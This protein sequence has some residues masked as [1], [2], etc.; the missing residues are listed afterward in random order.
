MAQPETIAVGPSHTL[1]IHAD[2]T[3][4]GCGYNADGRLGDGTTTSRIR[5]VRIGTGTTWRTV[6]VGNAPNYS[7]ALA[8]KTDGSLWSW[9]HNVAALGYYAMYDVLAPQLV[10]AGPWACAAA[11]TEHSVA[12]RA[13]GTLWTWGSNTIGQLGNGGTTAQGG[14]T[15]VGTDTD[16]AS[17]S[18]GTNYTLALKTNGTL[19]AWGRGQNL[20]IPN[21][22]LYNP[23][24]TRIGTASNWVRISAGEFSLGIRAD[25]TLWGWGNNIYNVLDAGNPNDVDAPRQLVPGTTWSRV[26][27]GSAAHILATQTNGTLWSW[28][29][30]G[31]GSLGDGSRTDSTIPVQVGS[32]NTWSRV[33]AGGFTSAADQTDGTLWMWGGNEY[34]QSG[35]PTLTLAKIPVPT[36]VGTAANWTTP[37]ATT[38]TSMG[39][40]A[41]NS[42]WTWGSDYIGLLGD[43]P[44]AN[45]QTVARIDSPATYIHLSGNSI[46]V[47]ALR[48]DSSLW[49]WGDNQFGQLGDGT[50]TA[51]L[52]PTSVSASHWKQLATS[53]NN[54]LAIRADGTLWGWGD[55]TYGQLGDGTTTQRTQ[56]VQVGTDRDWKQV[57]CATGPTL[58]LRTDGSLWA[59]GG[60]GLF[61][62]GSSSS[63]SNQRTPLRIGTVTTWAQLA[64]S[65]GHVLALRTDG[66]LWAWGNNT[67]G[68]L[69]DG[70]TTYRSTPVRIGTATDWSTVA[71][72][73]DDSYEPFSMALK[74]NGTL[75]TW[76]NN[77]FGQ[78]GSATGTLTYRTLPTQVGNAIWTAIAAGGT[79]ALG[80]Q[81]NGT[82]WAWGNNSS[83]QS[84]IPSF[85]LRPA[86]VQTGMRPA[87][88]FSL[89]S[90]SPGVGAAGATVTLTGVGL[91]AAQ[92]VTFGGVAAPGFT[93]NAAGT[94]LTVAVPAGAVS[95]RVAI[96]GPDGTAWSQTPFQVLAAPA[97]SSFAPATAAPGT[98]I[99]VMGTNLTGATS[100]LLG[101]V[102]ITGFVVNAAGTALTFMVPAGSTGG[103]I[104]VSTPLGAGTSATPL[105]IVLATAAIGP[106]AGITVAPVPVRVGQPLQLSA[107]PTGPLTVVL[108]NSLGQRMGGAAWPAAHSAEAVLDW[109]PAT[110]GLYILSVTTP[111][112]VLTR[113]IMVE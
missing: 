3:L 84:G 98:T 93:V 5:P 4:W 72:G 43:G 91:G 57:V 49:A 1:A 40:R 44:L 36:Q 11:G 27:G 104:S 22:G 24:P 80:V 97:I 96:L 71:T 23:S 65:G 68:E 13:D 59:W 29:R 9:G 32:S 89:A 50:T 58:A 18:A 42:L 33:A 61:G 88:S 74:R 76:G 51:R 55:N 41:D 60:P 107:L 92:L 108:F 21:V 79:H 20:G 86:S 54:S 102:A 47:L 39:L 85:S 95:G 77:Y 63:G 35:D 25:G 99:T 62:N 70:T 110:P 75:W 19:W 30:N 45:R 66:S 100:V 6:S 81:A 8:L 28:G 101:G 103:F 109:V 56:P 82:F 17:V 2:G 83:G 52:A 38:S 105:G 10:S 31:R 7:Y 111:T 112:Q 94:V 90:I 46:H 34:G 16:W 15:Q 69:G 78:L 37:A 53:G 67:V 73:P 12:V 87:T 113:R 14:P 48:A 64:T 26:A 106:A